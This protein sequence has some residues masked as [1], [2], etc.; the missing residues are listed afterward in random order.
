L[1]NDLR[2]NPSHL[3]AGFVQVELPLNGFRLSIFMRT[4]RIKLALQLLFIGGPLLGGMWPTARRIEVVADQ[5][6]LVCSGEHPV[7][8]FAHRRKIRLFA[9]RWAA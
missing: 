7:Q 9:M 3:G 4:N 2:I 8:L 6:D 5:R 1:L